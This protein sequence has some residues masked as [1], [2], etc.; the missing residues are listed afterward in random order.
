MLIRG[1]RSSAATAAAQEAVVASQIEK[2]DLGG[3][4]CSSGESVFA[5]DKPADDQ[6]TIVEHFPLASSI[7]AQANGKSRSEHVS[8]CRVRDRKELQR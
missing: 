7:I 5:T 8:S 1:S 2:L 6:G 4:S 3:Y